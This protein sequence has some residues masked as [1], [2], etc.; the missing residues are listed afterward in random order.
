[1]LFRRAVCGLKRSR[2]FPLQ[3][4]GHRALFDA[5]KCGGTSLER[6]AFIRLLS[7]KVENTFE[8][9]I[10][11]D[12]L[13]KMDAPTAYAAGFHYYELDAKKNDDFAAESDEKEDETEKL[14]PELLQKRGKKV[15]K[16]IRKQ[17]KAQRRKLLLVEQQK[18]GGG[19]I[20]NKAPDISN[21][22][23]AKSL[24]H[25]AASKDY[26][27]A[28]VQLGNIY[29]REEDSMAQAIKMYEIA[30][31]E[32]GHPDAL[33]NLGN[34]YYEQCDYEKA[35]HCFEVAS[36]NGD[37][38]ATFWLGYTY[39]RGLSAMVDGSIEV[40][41]KS[42]PKQAMKFLQKAADAGHNGAQ[43]YLA[44]A[45]R[46]SD[47]SL[48]VEKNHKKMW[49]YLSLALSD[50]DGEALYIVGDMHFNGSDG[51]DVDYGKALEYYMK[52]GFEG[53]H[54][55]ALCCAGSMYYNGLGTPRDYMAAFNLYQQSIEIDRD[56][57]Q[58]WKNIASMH[59]FGDGVQEDKEMARH[60]QK[61]IIEKLENE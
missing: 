45:Y 11:Q 47:E 32:G 12:V 5:I 30:G 10:P 54:S 33:Y 31:L 17:I 3:D 39:H 25:Y 19:D 58:A 1:M 13:E 36:K 29:L 24:L 43:I 8:S 2:P 44:Q 51:K 22:D 61:V 38:S 42:D 9:V 48:Q 59:Y 52:A 4:R 7:G 28:H 23:I 60:I 15:M 46:S 55:N 50:N 20:V 37:P 14:S 6:V 16:E 57:L 27:D 49:E 26:Y 35:M 53:R 56:N 34:I 18:E 40:I 21:L 41:V